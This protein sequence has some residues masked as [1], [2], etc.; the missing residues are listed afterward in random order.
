MRE[1]FIF[2]SIVIISIFLGLNKFLSIK[3]Q[4]KSK[5]FNLKFSEGWNNIMNFFI[6]GLISFYFIIIRWPQLLDGSLLNYSDI[7]LLVIFSMGMF[8]HLC[9]VSHNFTEG[10][11]SIIDKYVKG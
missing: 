2:L 8:G 4:Y 5:S 9:V 7:I 1:S 6:S 10:I 11:G 3:D